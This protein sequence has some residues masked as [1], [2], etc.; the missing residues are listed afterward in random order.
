MVKVDKYKLFPFLLW[1]P[2][3][4]RQT[5]KSDLIAGLTG[6][7]I[8]LPQGVAFALIAGLPPVY[9]MYT[10]MVTPI[11]AALFGSSYHLISGPTTALSLAIFS[12]LS[13]YAQPSTESFIALTLLLTLLVG[14]I[15][16]VLGL[17]RMGAL[18]N[19]VSH[20]VI[21]GFTLGAAILIATS[22]LKHVLG[23]DIGGGTS[24]LQTWNYILNHIEEVNLFAVAIGTGTLLVAVLLKKLYPSI[25]NLLI[26][27]LLGSFAAYFLND[28][29][30]A[31]DVVGAMPRG[32][33]P[34][35]VPN[36]NFEL[37]VQL[38]PNALAIALLG[39][40]EAIAISRGIAVKTRQRLNSNQE[41]IGQGL[42]NIVG[43]FFSCYVGS[44]SFTRSGA[45]YSSGAQTPMAA[46][47]AAAIL[48]VIMLAVAPLAE[49]L[50]MPTMG[51]IILLVAYNLIDVQHLKQVFKTS[52]SET[53]ILLITFFCT[54]FINIEFAIFAG[55]IFSLMFYLMRTSKPKVVLLAPN[56]ING[57]RKFM[58]AD[59]HQL[60]QCPQLHVIR[61][62][63]S[64]FFG[65][66]EN[67]KSVLF[68]LS[69]TK[70]HILLIGSGIN[71]I[72]S[73]GAEL[74]VDEAERL[75]SLGGGLY[76]SHLKKPVRDFMS[77][78][79]QSRIGESHFFYSKES[80]ISAIYTRLSVPIC[81][82]CTA[83][84]FNECN[85]IPK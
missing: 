60:A 19:F 66:V 53:V 13:L 20:S 49:Y 68:E 12:S 22:Q 17:A 2:L 63:G 56:T 21:I 71:F 42:S 69:N 41:F 9:G 39:L 38:T 24:F 54:L 15:Q 80:A 14:V 33:P 58:N 48:I 36:L 8:V 26:A 23:L 37:I 46:M 59:L 18:V 78:G 82:T 51:G 84:I 5:L 45:N 76:L 83:R 4:N 16:F 67:V 47:F 35:K 61:I 29:S 55:I 57:E 50:P 44:G 64:L 73:S 10:A 85:E 30:W 3:V 62:D 65:A 79:Y 74:L 28:R 75:H 11:V 32:L 81:K 43:S 40:I 72:D 77:R 6:A 34:F 31:I 27:L 25:P 1:G 52:R 70:N 7:I